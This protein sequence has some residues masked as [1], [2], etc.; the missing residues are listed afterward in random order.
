MSSTKKLSPK[1]NGAPEFLAQ[2]P[3]THTGPLDERIAAGKALRPQCSRKSHAE[4]SPPADRADPVELLIENSQ[5]RMFDIESSLGYYCT[6][7]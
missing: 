6:F 5:G 1:E 4:W 2:L 7:V 3:Q